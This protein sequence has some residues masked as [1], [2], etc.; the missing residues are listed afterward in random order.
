MIYNIFNVNFFMK[1]KP[2]ENHVFQRRCDDSDEWKIRG[3]FQKMM[4]K[5][6]L[7]PQHATRAW[8]KMNKWQ[9]VER[10]ERFDLS[11]AYVV[12]KAGNNLATGFYFTQT[13]RSIELTI[14]P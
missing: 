8:V 5:A 7:K 12:Q 4:I 1:L 11:W 10:P 6:G 14:A 2:S 3:K 13:Q 9:L